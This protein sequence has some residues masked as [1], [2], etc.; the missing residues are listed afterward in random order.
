MVSLAAALPLAATGL[1]PQQPPN[2]ASLERLRSTDD[3]LVLIDFDRT[4]TTGQSDQ[5][6]DVL[7]ESAQLPGSLRASFAPLLDF[8]RPFP[9]ELQGDS[10]WR[11]AN[12]I[13]LSHRQQI[14][15]DAVQLSVRRADIHLRPGAE[16][17]LRTLHAR[18][19]P[20]LVVSAGFSNV[21]EEVLT[22]CAGVD[23]ASYSVASNQLIFGEESGTL[24][25]IQP[26][27][28]V[29]SN[30][31]ASTYARNR[32]WFTRHAHRTR[33]LLLGDKISDLDMGAGARADGY[34]CVGVGI[35]NDEPDGANYPD[36]AAF[37]AAFD[38]LLVGD[39][40]S[41]DPLTQALERLPD[42]E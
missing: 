19:V 24:E 4:L 10:W 22:G 14:S 5:C 39:K 15:R 30:N 25:G 11:E 40:G 31:K 29:T 36:H 42:G 3:M 38:E 33:L 7:G 26:D 23:R 28:P 2:F 32:A 17:L 9:P 35:R 27:E 1:Q 18:R 37:A 16:R 6:H 12:R 13:L 34:V 8:S 20:T 41:L 21:V